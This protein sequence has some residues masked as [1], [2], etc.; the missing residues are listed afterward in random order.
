MYFILVIFIFRRI[1][2]IG[3]A[4]LQLFFTLY[5][6]IDINNIQLA[7]YNYFLVGPLFVSPPSHTLNQFSGY[8]GCLKIIIFRV[9]G[10]GGDDILLTK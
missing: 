6:D 1:H 8:T 2:Q 5:N 7:C 3:N 4:T 10:L 9:R